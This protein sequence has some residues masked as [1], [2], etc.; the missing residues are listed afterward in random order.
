M[1]ELFKKAKKEFPKGSIV[2][3]PDG[4]VFTVA[5]KEWTTPRKDNWID[6]IYY[7]CCE[8]INI[9]VMG[10]GETRGYYLFKDGI[11]AERLNTTG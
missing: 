10:D 4:E 11:W 1:K 5:K 8:E 6:G 7:K 3:S 2:K 9:L